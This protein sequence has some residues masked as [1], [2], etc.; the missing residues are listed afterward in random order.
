MQYQTL[1]ILN[2]LINKIVV[3]NVAKPFSCSL[4]GASCIWFLF[5][6]FLHTVTGLSP[7]NED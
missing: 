5:L 2:K 1:L 7:Q 3:K 4:L 6:G